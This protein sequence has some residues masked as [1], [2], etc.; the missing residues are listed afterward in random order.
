MA[1][2][3]FQKPDKV[4][5]LVTPCAAFF[6]HHSRVMLSTPSALLVS[7]MNSHLYLV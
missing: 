5:M 4:V 3:A 2:L 1:I 6:F 7:S